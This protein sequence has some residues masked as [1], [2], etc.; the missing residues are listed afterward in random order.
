MS[1]D[2]CVIKARCGQADLSALH[3]AGIESAKQTPEKMPGFGPQVRPRRI[4]KYNQ[5][6]SMDFVLDQLFDGR[7]SRSLTIVDNFSH[8]CLGYPRNAIHPRI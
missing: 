3:G 2:G 1:R 8:K 6:W 7:R 4:V 5:V